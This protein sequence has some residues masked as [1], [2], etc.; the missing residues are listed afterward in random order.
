MVKHSISDLRAA[1]ATRPP[2]QALAHFSS[3]LA[4]SHLDPSARLH[5]RRHFLDT[6]GS[7][8][9]GA[10]Q[11]ATRCVAAAL[12]Y[13]GETGSP[14]PTLIPGSARHDVGLLAGAHLMGTAA[15]GLELDDGYRP[16]MMHPG[17]VVIPPA[18]MLG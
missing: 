8:I 6:L 15:H 10:Q 18:L 16:G 4:W 3:V 14:S 5:A 9:A 17:C 11:A 1:A 13:A 2:T 7:A 12:D